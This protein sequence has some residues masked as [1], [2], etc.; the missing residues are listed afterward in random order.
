MLEYVPYNWRRIFNNE[1]RFFLQGIIGA[2]PGNP[3]NIS[4]VA[5]GA[6]ITAYRVF[7]CSGSVTDDSASLRTR[8]LYVL[9]TLSS[10]LVL[11]QALLT[12]V[13]EGQDILTMSL[14][15]ADGWTEGTSSVVSSRIAGQGKIVTIAAGND[16]A[17]GSWFTSGPGNAINA[18]SAASLD[19]CG[20]DSFHLF[21][22]A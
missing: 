16:G 19:K 14:G 18:I 7:G 9:L 20:P 12:G 10:F 1:H 11:V 15:G 5:F 13:K 3:F 17:E 4:G 6:S 21:Q 8:A 2:N 22:H